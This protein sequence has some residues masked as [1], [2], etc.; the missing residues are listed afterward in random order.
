MWFKY[1][2]ANVWQDVLALSRVMHPK[3][4]MILWN[5]PKERT[6]VL[7]ALH[8]WAAAGNKFISLIQW[9]NYTKLIYLHLW[10]CSATLWWKMFTCWGSQVFFMLSQ[11]LPLLQTLVGSPSHEQL[12]LSAQGG[13]WA[14]LAALFNQECNSW[15][16]ITHKFLTSI[17][18]LR[19]QHNSILLSVINCIWEKYILQGFPNITS[20]C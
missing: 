3:Q 14:L 7:S 9:W 13:S 10:T 5:M 4:G 6:P 20:S 17:S 2:K 16:V 15:S 19:N 18:S 11:P 8:P 12:L 1:N